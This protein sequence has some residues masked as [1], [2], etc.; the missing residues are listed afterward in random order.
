MGGTR[1]F[2]CTQINGLLYLPVPASIIE[3]QAVDVDSFGNILGWYQGNA[4]IHGVV[5]EAVTEPATLSLLSH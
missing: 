1:G 5:G 4:G 2:T 3:N